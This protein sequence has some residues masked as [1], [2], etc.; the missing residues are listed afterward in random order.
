MITKYNLNIRKTRLQLAV[1]FLLAPLVLLLVYWKNQKDEAKWNVGLLTSGTGLI[2]LGCVAIIIFESV[3]KN[4]KAVNM[5]GVLLNGLGGMLYLV[6]AIRTSENLYWFGLHCLIIF[7][8][9]TLAADC[10]N[11]MIFERKK[12]QTW[13]SLWL[14]PLTVSSSLSFA[15][16][17]F[18]TNNNIQWWEIIG[19]IGFGTISIFTL[20]SLLT[21]LFPCTKYSTP[22]ITK[23]FNSCTCLACIIV[24][25]YFG[26]YIKNHVNN[27]SQ[28]C[29]FIASPLLIFFQT[30]FLITISTPDKDNEAYRENIIQAENII[31]MK[32]IATVP[33]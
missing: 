33:E 19:K 10:S 14:Y 29:F 6:G 32:N 20:L 16:M 18:N 5:F 13:L 4:A 22:S 9:L 24:G 25:I 26:L 30:I 17:F 12:D 3:N 15:Y 8:A 31:E 2:L 28:A 27:M 21:L 1:G 7:D 11:H 23:L